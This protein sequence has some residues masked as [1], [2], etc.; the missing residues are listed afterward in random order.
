[1]KFTSSRYRDIPDLYKTIFSVWLFVGVSILPCLVI[2]VTMIEQLVSKDIIISISSGS[3]VHQDCG[4]LIVQLPFTCSNSSLENMNMSQLNNMFL[5]GNGGLQNN[6]QAR[7]DN[8]STKRV[9]LGL[10]VRTHCPRSVPAICHNMAR[11][12]SCRVRIGGS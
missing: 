9:T 5:N 1:M 2:C 3:I 8:A 12:C 4:D 6:K 11:S 7:V 10:E